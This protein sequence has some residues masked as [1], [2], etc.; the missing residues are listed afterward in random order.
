MSRGRVRSTRGWALSSRKQKKRNVPGQRWHV[1]V[2]EE[3]GLHGGLLSRTPGW[4]GDSGLKEPEQG[5]NSEKHGGWLPP[6]SPSHITRDQEKAKGSGA[7]RASSLL[8]DSEGHEWYTPCDPTRHLE[9]GSVTMTRVRGPGAPP[10]AE[11][12]SRLWAFRDKYD[13]QIL[14]NQGAQSSVGTGGIS[15]SGQGPFTLGVAA[16]GRCD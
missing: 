16:S 13:R 1:R 12:C 14:C 10:W 4:R 2:P 7:Q 8:S 5:A 6:H 15:A 3:Q 11:Q 9:E